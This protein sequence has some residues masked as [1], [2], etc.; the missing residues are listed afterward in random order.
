MFAGLEVEESAPRGAGEGL[1]GEYEV[2]RERCGAER[3]VFSSGCSNIVSS[4]NL[5]SCCAYAAV[6]SMMDAKLV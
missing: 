2:V 6:E 4:C 5:P 3:D 1:L